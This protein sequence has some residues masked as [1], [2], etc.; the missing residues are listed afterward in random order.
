MTG[1]FGMV[2]THLRGKR[3]LLVDDERELAD[4]VATILHGAGFASV[5]IANS[6][7]EA[8]SSIAARSASPEHAYQLFVLDVMMPGMDGFELCRIVRERTDAPIV[9][10][11]AKA[12]EE[13]AVFGL[14]VGADD[15][16]RKPFGAAELRAKVA[17]HLRREKRERVYALAFGDVRLDLAAR[18]LYVGEAPVALTKTE[19]DVCE[20]LARHPGQVFSRDQIV[21]G[22]LGWGAESDAATISVHVS[23]ARAK[24]KA[25]GA[26]P[27]H[28]VWGVGYKWIA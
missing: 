13:D 10:L 22:V 14:G 5:D 25:A 26:E 8:L 7:A 12:A 1:A 21:E 9:F 27:V 19:F 16:I 28:T 2:E 20:F 11:T 17:A 15:Y 6:S 3:I 24:R 23:N 18:E 4:M